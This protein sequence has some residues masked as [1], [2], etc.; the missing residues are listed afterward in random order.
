MKI[1]VTKE[2]LEKI[3]KIIGENSVG[4]DNSE[5]SKKVIGNDGTED[6]RS[7]HNNMGKQDNNS[8]RDEAKRIEPEELEIEPSRTEEKPKTI[9][10]EEYICACCGEHF[11]FPEGQYPDKCPKCGCIWR[12]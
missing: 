2:Q 5:H 6:N 8:N 7:E 10:L 11:K 4:A 12:S 9:K 1:Q 3:M